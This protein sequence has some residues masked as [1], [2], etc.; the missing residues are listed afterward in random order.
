[1]TSC[2][3]PFFGVGLTSDDILYGTLPL[4]HSSGG[5]ITLC[6][7]LFFG[8]TTVIRRKFSAS[9]F[10]KDCAKYNVTVSIYL[11]Y[12]CSCRKNNCYTLGCQLHWRNL[13]VFDH[14]AT[15]HS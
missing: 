3:G 9:N 6:G 5:Q 10:W 14:A 15:V 2:F 13:S 1:M 4:Y 8:C 7:S 11:I 12:K